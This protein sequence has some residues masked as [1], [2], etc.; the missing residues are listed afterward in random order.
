MP[1]TPLFAHGWVRGYNAGV[2]GKAACG[3]RPVSWVARPAQ[4]RME[5]IMRRKLMS[6]LGVLLCLSAE[7]LAS[8]GPA[9][10]PTVVA[11]APTGTPVPSATATPAWTPTSIPTAAPTVTSMPTPPRTPLPPPISPDFPTG[12]FLHKHPV[13]FCVFQFNEDGTWA[14]FWKVV[15]VDVSGREPYLRG[16]YIIDGRL[17]TERRV[18][19]ASIV[20]LRLTHGLV[21]RPWLSKSSARTRVLT[22]SKPMKA[23]CSG[24]R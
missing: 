21:V 15:S 14:F 3:W 5:G 19:T 7:P 20:H 4:R 9:P 1:P 16:T 11:V 23:H 8:C 12:T 18:L 24:Q 13:T 10:T 22:D 17:Y 2:Q 6:I